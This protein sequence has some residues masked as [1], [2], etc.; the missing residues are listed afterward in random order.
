MQVGSKELIR[1]INN[2]IVLETIIEYEP[3]SRAELSKKLG[4]TKATISSIVKDLLKQELIVEVGIG[5]A[6]IGRRPILL[7]FNQKAGYS[8]CIDLGVETISIMLTD[9]KGRKKAIK[10]IDIP[11][12]N[13]D[14]VCPILIPLIDDMIKKTKPSRYGLVGITIGI[15]G[16][17]Y[18]N[19][20][21]FTPYYNLKGANLASQLEE[22]Y[23]IPVYLLNEANLSVLGEKTFAINAENMANIN[24]H[25]GIGVGLVINNKLYEG[26]NGFAGEFGHTIIEA[27]GKPCPCGNKGCIEQ[28]ASE[29]ALLKKLSTMKNKKGITFNEFM[30]LYEKKDKYALIIMDDFIK[31]ISIALNNILTAFNPEIIII[32]S[33][34][35]NQFPEILEN[36]KG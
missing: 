30:T 17:V 15:H 14:N 20:V 32:N 22:H 28:Y 23:G 25:W 5:R 12:I 18:D 16:V 26:Y 9:L 4:L 7:K 27:D 13:K 34:F 33:K 21:I 35:T 11:E 8:I 24:I 36:I 10:I 31:Y 29:R 6:D 2:N 1:D 3:I 19:D